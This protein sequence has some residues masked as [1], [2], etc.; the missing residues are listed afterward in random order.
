MEVMLKQEEIAIGLLDAQAQELM[1]KAKELYAAA[2]AC[3]EVNIKA[4][5]VLNEQVIAITHQEQAVAEQE[6]ELQE[7]KEDVTG[8]LERGCNELLSREA[9]HDT[10]ETTLEVDWKSMGD[11]CMAVLAHELTADL[12]ANHLAF[13]EKELADREKQLAITQH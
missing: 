13:R 11:L 4:Q 1:E 3:G 8:T 10:H 5:E 2:E 6:Q 12:K 7:E 9:D